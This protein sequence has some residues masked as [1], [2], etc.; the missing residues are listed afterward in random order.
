MGP[1]SCVAPGAGAF[2]SRG[3]VLGGR[4]PGA[5]RALSAAGGLVPAGMVP[6]ADA[7][8]GHGGRIWKVIHSAEMPITSRP[9][10]AP[11]VTSSS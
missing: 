5:G 3:Q 2:T 10:A 1:G 8:S 7:G 9:V 6:R 4:V 11:T